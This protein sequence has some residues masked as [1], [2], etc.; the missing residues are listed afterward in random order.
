MDLFLYHTCYSACCAASAQLDRHG[1]IH[2]C[3]ARYRTSCIK[4]GNSCLVNENRDLGC[5]FVSGELDES[6][7][8]LE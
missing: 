1:D 2:A 5:Q 3:Q 7:M 4:W 6:E 8:D